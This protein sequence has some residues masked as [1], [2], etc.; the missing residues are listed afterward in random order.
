M[1]DVSLIPLLQYREY[2][3]LILVRIMLIK[4]LKVSDELHSYSSIK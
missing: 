2:L 1:A 3:D 4:F